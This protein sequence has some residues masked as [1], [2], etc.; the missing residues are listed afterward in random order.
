MADKEAILAEANER[1][2]G[3]LL[4]ASESRG[5]LTLTIESGAAATVCLELRDN[6]VFAF[7]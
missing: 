2:E 3:H 7:E 1:F 5:E 6:P 4:D